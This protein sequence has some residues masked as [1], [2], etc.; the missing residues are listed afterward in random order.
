[1]YVWR[2]S[3]GRGK[4]LMNKRL[5]EDLFTEELPRVYIENCPNAEILHNS[6]RL[7][8]IFFSVPQST[9]CM[10]TNLIPPKNP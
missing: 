8:L 9:H 5:R 3:Y 6:V 7:G 4:N 1:M 2:F 10:P